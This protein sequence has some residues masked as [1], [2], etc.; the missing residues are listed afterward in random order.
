MLT[1][2]IEK[3]V[4]NVVYKHDRLNHYSVLEKILKVTPSNND[5]YDFR[6]SK[7]KENKSW[8]NRIKILDYELL[9]NI[10][11]NDETYNE[12]SLYEILLNKYDSSIGRTPVLYFDMKKDDIPYNQDRPEYVLVFERQDGFDKEIIELDNILKNSKETIVNKVSENFTDG[13]ISNYDNMSPNSLIITP[14]ENLWLVP[15]VN[16]NSRE[17]EDFTSTGEGEWVLKV[18]HPIK[19]YSYSYRC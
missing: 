11:F 18:P 3:T 13:L 15:E 17:L 19:K 9:S 12:A 1:N 14:S 16:T 5:N 8:F 6:Y 2:Q 10:A 7:R 4:D